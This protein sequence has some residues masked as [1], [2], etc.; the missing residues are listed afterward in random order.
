MKIKQLGLIDYCIGADDIKI[1]SMSPDT[2]SATN[3][4]HSTN[5]CSFQENP[6]EPDQVFVPSQPVP[7][8][9]LQVILDNNTA[10]SYFI[11]ESIHFHLFIAIILITWL[12]F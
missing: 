2:P 7:I 4:C 1:E 9:P 11:G 12:S 8:L 3:V 10:L 6:T 5:Y